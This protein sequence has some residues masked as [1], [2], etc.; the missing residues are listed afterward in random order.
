MGQGSLILHLVVLI[1]LI[2]IDLSPY[3]LLSKPTRNSLMD[4]TPG[5]VNVLINIDLSPFQLL[6][7]PTRNSPMDATPSGVNSLD[8]YRSKPVPASF[9]T[10][11]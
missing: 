9:L 8:Q 6:S 11:P 10:Y 7:N 3:Q 5:G 2:K 1:V 4:N